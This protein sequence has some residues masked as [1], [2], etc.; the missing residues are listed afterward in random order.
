MLKGNY[1]FGH[2]DAYI[3]PEFM[4]GNSYKVDYLLI[5]KSSRGYEFVF[6]ELEKPY[7]KRLAMVNWGMLLEKD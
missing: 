2:H 5:G 7:W 1:N 4:L 3:I 6:I